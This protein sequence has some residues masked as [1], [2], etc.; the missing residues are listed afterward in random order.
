MI[1]SVSSPSNLS[2]HTYTSLTQS[3]LTHS[4]NPTPHNVRPPLTIFA[5]PSLQVTP[6]HTPRPRNG[7][8]SPHLPANLYS[9]GCIMPLFA[10]CRTCCWRGHRCRTAPRSAAR[11]RLHTPRLYRAR[12]RECGREAPRREYE[13]RPPN[14]CPVLAAK[15]QTLLLA[16]IGDWNDACSS[17][18]AVQIANWVCQ[19]GHPDLLTCLVGEYAQGEQEVAPLLAGILLRN[20]H[21]VFNLSSS[22]GM[23]CGEVTRLFARMQKNTADSFPACCFPWWGIVVQG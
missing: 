8:K 3:S 16:L 18:P 7:A 1:R 9:G 22:D 10:L 12:G 19:Y 23:E 14:R 13:G 6:V 5:L 17:R 15:P 2:A 11:P 4:L 20:R 21:N